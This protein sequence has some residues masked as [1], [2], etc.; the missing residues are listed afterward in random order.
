MKRCIF[1]KVKFMALFLFAVLM[2][3]CT[4]DVYEPKPDPT[5]E[6][7]PTP[8]NGGFN[9]GSALNTVKETTLTVV[10]E[11]L[12]DGKYYYTVEAFAEN[13]AI[14]TNAKSVSGSSQKTN[15]RIPYKRDISLPDVINKLFV[16]V[17]DPFGGKR[18]YGLD[19]ESTDLVLDLNSVATTTKSLAYQGVDLRDSK[20]KDNVENAIE[21]TKN[22]FSLQE[23]TTYFV[24][25]GV[26]VTGLKFPKEVKNGNI[27]LYVAGEATISTD[28]VKL[29][30]NSSIIIMP[31]GILTAKELEWENPTAYIENSG[32]LKLDELEIESTNMNA[33]ALYNKEGGLIT[34]KEALD[35]KKC[36]VKNECRIEA[37]KSEWENARITMESG[38]YMQIGDSNGGLTIVEGDNNKKP[39]IDLKAN[40]IFYSSSTVFEGNSQGS[41]QVVIQG[42]SSGDAV[43]WSGSVNCRTTVHYQGRVTVEYGS[44]S[45]QCDISKG[46][47]MTQIRGAS[48]ADKPY[49]PA[50][51]KHDG[52]GVKPGGEVDQPD[53]DPEGTDS[54]PLS[55]TCMF[56][57][58]WPAEGDYDMNDVVM[59]YKVVYS[60]NVETK[61]GSAEIQMTVLAVGATKSL[62][63]GYQLNGITPDAVTSISSDL[64]QME[65]GQT[66]VVMLPIW[67]AHK[68][69][70]PNAGHVTMNTY[71]LT[72][73]PYECTQTIYFNKDV[74]IR[75]NPFIVYG[76]WN[77]D[78]R[79]E[80]HLPG[81]R[82]T[83][84]A[85]TTSKDYDYY[86]NGVMWGIRVAN[87]ESVTC[88]KETMNIRDAY[89]GF[90]TWTSTG[91]NEN[92]AAWYNSPIADNV[93]TF[94][95]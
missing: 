11:D 3:A 12:Y 67:D 74:S 84:K 15:A 53:T 95:E 22:G 62:A 73:S 91:S 54:N 59:K 2:A 83:D 51:C 46:A 38:S 40:S 76:D 56:E 80:I 64:G 31:G 57:D 72:N 34:I 52:C 61:T 81:F 26:N 43:F 87:M 44:H 27:V 9:Q 55:F 92:G 93:I 86:E 48:F 1:T 78:K 85:N 10:V 89:E 90:A 68:A 69:L 45:G 49:I 30:Q 65:S 60:N 16:Q 8:G 75:V 24:P 88:P 7:K 79:S 25:S 82:G 42:P 41:S 63:I 70:D 6:P 28:E 19:I 58:N 47:S 14:V 4:T 13:P 35:L 50:G 5:P 37:G 66:N 29:G 36:L 94:V 23:K 18:T 77:S 39:T 21:I 17:T 71:K 32:T 20:K 33:F